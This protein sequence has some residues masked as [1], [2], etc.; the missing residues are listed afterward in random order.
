MM[1][2]RDGSDGEAKAYRSHRSSR[3]SPSGGPRRRPVKWLDMDDGLPVA[4]E[5]ADSGLVAVRV[6]FF[7]KRHP[8]RTSSRVNVCCNSVSRN[9]HPRLQPYLIGSPVIALPM[10][11]R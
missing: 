4:V 3:W 8:G 1:T 9:H 7:P 11:S 5:T 2:V 10:T 6:E